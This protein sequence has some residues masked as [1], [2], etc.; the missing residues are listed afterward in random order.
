MSRRCKLSSTSLLAILML[1]MCVLG[2]HTAFAQTNQVDSKLQLA[3]DA[4]NQAF[5]AVLDAEKAGANVNSLLNQLNDAS[6]LLAQAENIY[7]IGDN[8]KAAKDADAA[9][10][11]AK[12]VTAAAQ[13]AKGS[14]SASVQAAVF[15]TVAFA[16]EGAVVFVLALFLVW[17]WFKRS[18][19]NSLS[20][21]KPEVV[22]Q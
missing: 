17:R 1:S 21:A 12:Q 14:V 2:V 9:R 19:I 8:N 20:E 22:S 18:Y 6:G 5:K 4:V 13:T 7:R 10:L 3:N 16:V 11:I 15:T